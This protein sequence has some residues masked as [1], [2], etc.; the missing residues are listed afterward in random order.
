MKKQSLIYP[1]ITACILAAGSLP[2]TAG[3]LRQAPADSI[4]YSFQGS[5]QPDESL[6]G[7]DYAAIHQY[8]RHLGWDYTEHPNS[9]LN[10]HHTG[11][12]IEVV[13]DDI[14]KQYV[15]KFMNHAGEF[16]DG[17]RGSLKDRQRNEMKSQTIPAWHK[18]NGHWEGWQ[19][20]EWKF[21]IP[22]GFQ[23]S[24]SF[25]HIHQLKSQEGNNGAPLITITPRCDADGSNRRM[26]VI[27]TGDNR[28]S[29]KGVL[30]DHIPL[31]EFENEWVQVETEMYY[32][33]HGIFR[34]KITR[35]SDG[36]VLMNQSFDDIDLWRK[37]ASNIRNK[38]GIYRSLG[39]R[40]EGPEDRPTNGI[41]DEHIYL[42]DF[43]VFSWEATPGK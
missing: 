8:M 20:L 28:T 36:K 6:T 16:L 39:R 43:K 35:I 2:C 37:G 26:Q 21:K 18:L 13:Y 19:R 42:T 34:I 1:I 24:T 23:P 3:D 40:M 33:H 38:F 5:M 15:F 32:T 29:S 41:K 30:I 9:S 11:K 25:C 22:K 10:D 31:Q 14:L 7:K 27:H 4:D 12:H 17:D